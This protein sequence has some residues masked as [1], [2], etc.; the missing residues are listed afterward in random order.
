MNKNAFIII[1]IKIVNKMD[2]SLSIFQKQFLPALF[3]SCFT[4]CVTS[5]KNSN[6]TPAE[7]KCLKSCYATYVKRNEMTHKGFGYEGNI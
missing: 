5:F 4:E 6:L 2:E 1:I 7:G 3:Q